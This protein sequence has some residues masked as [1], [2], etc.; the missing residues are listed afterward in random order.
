MRYRKIPAECDAIQFT[1]E[2]SFD[3]MLKMWG[4]PF[5]RMTIFYPSTEVLI[6]LRKQGSLT[7]STTDWVIRQGSN[8]YRCSHGVFL[9][10]YE[11]ILPPITPETPENDLR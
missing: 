11:Q 6:L 3:H 5:E 7:V 2:S 10:N 8:F 4:E 9:N 1:G